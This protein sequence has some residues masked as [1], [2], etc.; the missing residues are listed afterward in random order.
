MSGPTLNQPHWV[1]GVDVGH[2]QLHP[3]LRED[4]RVLCVEK[5]NAR[6]LTAQ[7]LVLAA[8]AQA[9]PPFDLVVGDL[10]FISQTL[11]WPALRPLLAPQGR[12]LML[13]TGATTFCLS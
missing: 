13:V 3:R 4:A 12:M 1:V 10:S 7:A 8:G 5:C 2:G 6:E 11:V 9:E